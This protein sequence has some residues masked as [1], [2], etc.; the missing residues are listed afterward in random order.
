[1]SVKQTNE[2]KANLSNKAN[3]S[4]TDQDYK[5]QTKKLILSSVMIKERRSKTLSSVDPR[6]NSFPSF[7][8][9]TNGSVSHPSS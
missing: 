8:V 9:S 2:T 6:P 1:M 3:V 7:S 5:N 4:K